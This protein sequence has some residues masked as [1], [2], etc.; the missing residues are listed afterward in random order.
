MSE[1]PKFT[2]LVTLT[3]GLTL[4][5]DNCA[6]FQTAAR[7]LK[8][9]ERDFAR[10]ASEFIDADVVNYEMVMSADSPVLDGDE[11]LK[12]KMQHRNLPGEAAWLLKDVFHSGMVLERRSNNTWPLRFG[13]GTP[14]CK[15]SLFGA[16]TAIATVK[17]ERAKTIEQVEAVFAEYGGPTL[18]W[19]LI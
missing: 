6:E 5:S 8:N 18:K 15:S 12:K 10:I 17:L 9:A 19:E 2:C 4:R 13:D 16:Y 3:L 7:Q 14:Y 1:D 11:V